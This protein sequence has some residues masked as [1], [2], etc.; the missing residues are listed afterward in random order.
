MII[1]NT[2]NYKK[3][4]ASDSSWDLSYVRYAMFALA[5]IF[6]AMYQYYKKAGEPVIPTKKSLNPQ[7][8]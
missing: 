2:F 5:I 8:S 4:S 3:D 1:E 6:V 7:R